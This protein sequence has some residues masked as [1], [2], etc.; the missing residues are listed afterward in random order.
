[1]PGTQQ[2]TVMAEPGPDGRFGPFGGRFVPEALIP[3]CERARGGVPVRLGRPGFPCRARRA[4]CATTPAGRPR[5]ATRPGCPRCWG[6][7]CCSSAR[8]SPTPA[9]TRSTTCWARRCWPGGWARPRWSPRPARASTASP[10]PPRPRTWAWAAPSSWAS[11]DVARQE[12]NVFR[13]RLLGAEVVPVTSGS[14]TLKDATNEALRHWVTTVDTTH[15]CLGSVM[16]PHPYP[17]MV[18]EFQRVIGDEARGQCA[19]CWRAR[20][21][22]GRGGGLRGRRL[23]RGGDL[24]RL[25]RHPGPAGGRRG[26]GR[27]RDRARAPRRSARLPLPVPAGRVR[28]DHRGGH[29]LRGPGLPGDRPRARAPGRDRAGRVPHGHRRGGGRRLGAVRPHRGHPARAGARA[30][31]G[32]AAAC[33][34]RWRRAGRSR[35][36]CSPCPAAATRTPP[37]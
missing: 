10:R 22:P 8:I 7:A 23:E 12:L 2:T 27:S 15:Y 37:R 28:P 16:G 29:D 24:R 33:G 20:R 30:R 9:A 32:L 6:C 14:R 34:A 18:R 4:C 17:W 3:A 19:G 13:M 35:P 5:S 26:R 25:R 11:V 1:M 21:R 36:C 31:A